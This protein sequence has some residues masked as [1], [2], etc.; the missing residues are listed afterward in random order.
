MKLL[1]FLIVMLFGATAY[2][3]PSR[4]LVQELRKTVQVYVKTTSGEGILT[5]SAFPIDK[6]RLIT[7]GHFCEDA[8]EGAKKLELDERIYI[9]YL[10]VN[11]E[12]TTTSGGRI[13]KSRFDDHQDL[14]IIEFPKHGIAPVS[15]AVKDELKFGDLVYI[16]GAPLGVF[17]MITEGYVSQPYSEGMPTA[18]LD[19]KLLISGITGRGNSGGPIFNEKGEV[20]GVVVMVNTTYNHIAFAIPLRKI[21]TFLAQP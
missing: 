11:D 16:V 8:K 2:A 3:G 15:L 9:R 7:A 17:P 21:V 19:N 14:C 5:A 20:V 4:Q 1:C 10:N 13:V 6:S 18:R 12:I